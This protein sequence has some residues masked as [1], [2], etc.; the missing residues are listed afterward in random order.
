MTDG[1]DVTDVPGPEKTPSKKSLMARYREAPTWL[2]VVIP[3]AVVVVVVGIGALIAA[4]LD[5]DD[6]TTDDDASS[7]RIVL[8][9]FSS[10]SNPR[11]LTAWVVTALMA[12]QLRPAR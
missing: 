6:G 8:C 10:A 9:A 4:A 3:V 5:D 2:K 12:V 11:A 7:R 1:G